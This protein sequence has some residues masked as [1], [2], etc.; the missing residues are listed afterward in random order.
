[1]KNTLKA[2]L[3]LLSLAL[4]ALPGQAAPLSITSEGVTS[5]GTM[6]GSATDFVFFNASDWTNPGP[7]TNVS[8]YSDLTS[9]TVSGGI[10][11]QN[12]NSDSYSS[13][14]TPAGG[15]PVL[16]GDL[17]GDTGYTPSSDSVTTP[18]GKTIAIGLTV[19]SN[20]HF[21]YNDFNVFVMFT[22]TGGT[23]TDDAIGLVGPGA[24][25]DANNVAVTDVSLGQSSADYLEFNVQNLKSSGGTYLVLS[26]Y[27]T[28]ATAYLGAVSFESI[29][30]I[31]EPST[32]ALMLGGLAFLGFLIRRKS[33]R[34][35]V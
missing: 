11:S 4:L 15:S 7:A 19:G 3:S 14:T 5:G 9:F 10:D 29:A 2:A 31:P 17:F 23:Y 28:G 21:N 20:P 6:P 12:G 34:F 13:I 35:S 33:A 24:Q 1:M 8:P 27:T 26:S 16:T 32:Y 18:A 30:E 22:N 25:F